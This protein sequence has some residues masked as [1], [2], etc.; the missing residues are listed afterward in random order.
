M[1]FLFD[2]FP[3]LL[4]FIAY[5]FGGIYVATAV[6]I[7]ASALQVA[8]LLLRRKKV[9]MMMWVSL[10]IILVLGGATLVSHDEN[11]IKWKPTALYWIFASALL[12]SPIFFKKNIIRSMLAEKI[13]LP[14]TTWRKLNLSWVAFFIAMGVVNR[15]VALNYSTY[16]WVNFKLFGATAMMFTFI[17]AQSLVLNKFLI[18]KN[19]TSW[20]AII[21]DDITDSLSRRA[22]ARS[23]HLARLTELQEAGRLLLAGPFPAIDSVDPGQAGFSGSLVVAEFDS[24][25][26]AQIWADNDPYVHAGVYAQVRVKPFRKVLPL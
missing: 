18:T 19:M 7:A 4:F 23:A 8:F 6:S 24:L 5:K 26:A 21:S 16:V 17:V 1:K 20:Y 22:D 3:I 11:F 14:E 12:L 10:G 2:L 13:V 9:D 25:D 15:Y